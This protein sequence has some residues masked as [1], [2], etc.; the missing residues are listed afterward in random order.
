MDNIGLSNISQA[1]LD[2][3]LREYKVY[4]I[5]YFQREYSW[6][7]DQWSDFYEDA[8][9]AKEDD[10]PHF[11]G[12]MTFRE[13][14]DNKLLI[15]EGQQRFTTVMILLA[16]IRDLFY[17]YDD[18]KWEK[19][20]TSIKYEDHLVPD[21]PP[22]YKLVLSEINKEFFQ[23]KILMVGK[24][25]E[26]IADL[27][28]LEPR[29]NLSNKLIY[30]CY[31]YFNTQINNKIS[32]FGPRQKKEFLID[33]ERTVLRRFIIIKTEVSDNKAAY[34][35]FQTLNDRGL[36]LTITDLIKIYLFDHVGDDLSDA[37]D[38]WD[39]I[40]DILSF[41][42]TNTFFRHYWL[43][44]DGPIKE[45]DLLN[46]IEAKVKSKSEVF[47][48]LTDLKNEAEYYDALL[49]RSRDFWEKRSQ[50]IVDL[51]EELQILSKMQ[52][53]PLLM[54]SCKESHFPT[55]EFIKL[56][57]ICIN[58][59]FRYLTIGEKENKELERLFSDIARGIRNGDISNTKEVKAKL[60]YENIDDVSFRQTFSRKQVKTVKL[61]RYILKKIEDHLSGDSEKVAKSITLEH[62][63]PISPNN[64][65]KQYLSKNGMDKD[66]YVYRLG[67]L[68]L[69]A[70]KSN[71]KAQS[72][73]FIKKR[74]NIY[75]KESNLKINNQLLHY[76]DWKPEDIQD[77][78]NWL[79]DLAVKI[80]S[81]D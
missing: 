33:V 75:R 25:H 13:D 71:T 40:R 12:F 10:K 9:K 53:M 37:K 27:N 48:F 42:N 64:E 11:F 22:A 32:N 63:L 14:R 66:D 36:D 18:A 68:T 5:P 26:K 44:C 81:L 16:L 15:I 67:N 20:E 43:S 19:Y 57:Q 1:T 35:I 62:I 6:G 56:I 38:K 74:D 80:W 78:Q 54:A 3:L 69:L 65:W 21:N 46:A 30:E 49:N 41:Q 72:D 61:A 31:I 73:F 28:T 2:G 34:N 24:P 4:Q 59:I 60:V 47:K 79:A 45:R 51:L 76:N 70:D 50:P 8:I 29:M 58:Y 39:E 7:K 17:S 77:R 55:G 52:P 23:E